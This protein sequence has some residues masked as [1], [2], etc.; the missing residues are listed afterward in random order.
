MANIIRHANS[1]SLKPSEIVQ[2]TSTK[3]ASFLASYRDTVTGK[4]GNQHHIISSSSTQPESTELINELTE[5]QTP[6][7]PILT[8]R[9]LELSLNE[10][11]RSELLRRQ[12][13]PLYS[14]QK[15]EAAILVPLCTVQ[16]TPSILFTRRSS[17]LSTHAS[18]IS[19]PGG[20]HDEA[21]DSSGGW[22]NKLINTALREMKEELLYDIDHIGL[23]THANCYEDGDD[24]S[25]SHFNGQKND[26][27][28]VTVLGQT[29]PVP[30]LHGTKV[31]PIV[32]AINYDLPLCTSSEF[33][34]LFPGNPEEVDYIFTVPLSYLILNE[35]SE[36][37][38]RWSTN[39]DD[40]TRSK[41]NKSEAL[42]PVFHIPDSNKK[43]DGDKIWGF[44]AIVLRSLMRKVFWPVFSDAGSGFGD[45]E[46]V[47]RRN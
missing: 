43:R 21:L 31:T 10:I 35:T 36:P 3:I 22:T 6:H 34:E 5:W 17:K 9:Q 32:G 14:P 12:E 46:S 26:L 40:H 45:V 11:R 39:L 19:F 44:T 8:S 28:L 33:S 4:S 7:M 15:R 29:Q 25:M 30:S 27:P 2:L 37:L 1:I 20:N 41:C 47:G 23:E 38:Q 18:E 24:C 42:G 13:T 16:G